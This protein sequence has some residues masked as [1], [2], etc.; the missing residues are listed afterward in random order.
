MLID[1]YGY[2]S[3]NI[4]ILRDDTK[5]SAILPT[6]KNIMDNLSDVI[7]N[8]GKYEELWI[9]YSGHGSNIRDRNKDEADGYDEVI[10]PLDFRQVG[11][12]CGR[13]FCQCHRFRKRLF[14]N[15]TF[16]MAPAP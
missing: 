15:L 6:A 4:T 13:K 11:I 3:S 12:V 10:V 2:T 1:A 5:N 7:A 8:S 14:T 9:H 16:R